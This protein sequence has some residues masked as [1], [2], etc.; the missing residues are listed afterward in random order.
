MEVTNNK[1]TK[2]SELAVMLMLAACAFVAVIMVGFI[3]L[4]LFFTAIPTVAEIGFFEFIFGG[5]WDPTREEVLY[6]CDYMLPCGNPIDFSVD[7]EAWRYCYECCFDEVPVLVTPTPLFGIRNLILTSFVGTFGAILIG[8][9]IGVLAAIAI[10]QILPKK[11]SSVVTPAVNL[12]AG[13]PSVV[14]GAVGGIFLVPLVQ[15]V[16]GLRTGMT[17]FSAIIVL[18][19]MVLPTIISISTTS[20]NAVPKTYMEASLALGLTKEASLYKIVIPAA[21][22]GILTSVLLGLGRALGEGM[23]IILVA[24]NL[25]QFPRL[26]EGARF[27]TTGIVAEFGYSDGL[28]RNTLFS[29]GAVLFVFVLAINSLF[30][31]IIKK[32]G[33][34][35]G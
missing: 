11:M 23:A 25:A 29:I 34:N 15:N 18:S 1:K 19:I 33:K 24:G 31:Y 27:L 6:L 9:P 30:H 32:A 22:S 28:H 2:T 4:F 21:K 5:V 14:Y 12:L 17:L 3:V 16:F 13:I 8:V 35:N 20:I 26:F 7:W 10:A